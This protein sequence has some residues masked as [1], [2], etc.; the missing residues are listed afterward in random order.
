MREARSC[1]ASHRL[2]TACTPP[3]P[4]SSSNVSA[5]GTI[6]VPFGEV[7]KH[8]LLDQP[9]GD[10]L[11]LERARAQRGAV[12]PAPL[13]HEDVEADLARRAG[14]AHA[15]HGDPAAGGERLDVA[16]EVRG[17]DQLEDHVEGT[18]APRSPRGRSRGRPAPRRGREAPRCGPLR[19]RARR[20]LG[21][22][23][24][25]RSRPRPRRRVR[26]GARPGRSCAW[27]KSASCAVVKTSGRPPAAGQS[28]G[29]GT[30]IAARSCTTASSAWPPPPTTAITRSPSAKRSAPGPSASTSPASSRP[31]MSAR[32]AGRCRVGAPPLEHVRPV[33]ARRR[34][35]EPAARPC[36][37]RDRGAP[38]PPAPRPGWLRHAPAGNL[39]VPCQE[40]V[41]RS[42]RM[43][44]LGS[45]GRH[46]RSKPQL[47]RRGAAAMAGGPHRP[48]GR[49]ART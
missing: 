5:T 37:A 9:H 40:G 35:R 14:A 11:L 31:G 6:S 47:S 1:R 25:P 19:S 34:A 41:T 30:G 38:P 24:R 10:R 49:R 45:R 36:R 27:L 21:R 17:S 7:R 22:A 42:R 3:L 28:S 44:T 8:L 26:A 23:A 18:L 29:S 43:P 48:R 15:D 4:G 16:L 46:E 33:Q 2:R 13:L 20:P 12:D 39:P 32:G